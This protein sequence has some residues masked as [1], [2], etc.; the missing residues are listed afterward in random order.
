VDGFRADADKEGHKVT[1]DEIV[2][3]ERRH[4]ANNEACEKA[5]E[6]ASRAKDLANNAVYD[7]IRTKWF[8][9]NPAA[10]S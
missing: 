2:P 7:E 6:Q 8:T 5:I 9:P 3:F 10:K 4:N 1:N